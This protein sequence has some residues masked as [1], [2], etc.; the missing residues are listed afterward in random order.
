M[1]K[2]KRLLPAHATLATQIDQLADAKTY[3]FSV[4]AKMRRKQHEV[5]LI[6]D[7]DPRWPDYA[8]YESMDDPQDPED[9]NDYGPTTLMYLYSGETHEFLPENRW[10]PETP[11]MSY[12]WMNWH[13]VSVLYGELAAREDV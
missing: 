11:P 12:G 13:Q 9:E 2:K 7:S 6:L 8:I 1:A 10:S 5:R 4:W 3:V